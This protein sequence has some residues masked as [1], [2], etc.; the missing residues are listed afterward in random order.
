MTRLQSDVTVC[1]FCRRRHLCGDERPNELECRHLTRNTVRHERRTVPDRPS[2]EPVPALTGEISKLRYLPSYD[3]DSIFQT[4]FFPF[5]FFLVKV[6]TSPETSTVRQSWP[7]SFVPIFAVLQKY[8]SSQVHGPVSL[9]LPPLPNAPVIVPSSWTIEYPNLLVSLLP[10]TFSMN[11]CS[12]VILGS[13]GT[14]AEDVSAV[15]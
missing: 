10:T 14:A 2:S 13:S 11:S 8:W 9:S 12:V 4:V 15:C 5:P 3:P 6:T 7:K 1:G